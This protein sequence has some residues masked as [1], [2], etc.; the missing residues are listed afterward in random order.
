[1][2][3]DD[4]G[5][6][7]RRERTPGWFRFEEK[8][9]LDWKGGEEGKRGTGKGRRG[10]NWGGRGWRR[11]GGGIMCGGRVIGSG[12]RRAPCNEIQTVA[13]YSTH[14]S[15]GR[16]R[17]WLLG[18]LEYKNGNQDTTKQARHHIHRFLKAKL[19]V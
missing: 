1:M 17:S 3:K 7:R 19:Q 2:W 16:N 5:E 18:K 14:F 13:I 10:G 4:R 9:E 15:T 8:L 12:R 6:E 11:W